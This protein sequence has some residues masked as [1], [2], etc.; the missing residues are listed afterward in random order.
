VSG[1]SA[2]VISEWA[3]GAS[4]F[5][6]F[7]NC[8]STAVPGCLANGLAGFGNVTYRYADILVTGV[9]PYAS[10]P[11]TQHKITMFHNG[12]IAISVGNP[13]TPANGIP[14]SAFSTTFTGRW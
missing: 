5:G 8:S 4:W 9:N 1:S 3:S 13:W 2:E 12:Q 7:G 10:F 11:V 14:G 6:I